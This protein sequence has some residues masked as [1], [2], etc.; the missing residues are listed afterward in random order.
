MADNIEA[1]SRRHPSESA[2]L[3]EDTL[4]PKLHYR[5]VQQRPTQVSRYKLKGYRVVRPSEDGVETLYDQE[6]KPAE[7]IIK[8]GDRVLMAIP[9]PK[10]H[11]LAARVKE[12]AISRLQTNEEKFR[13]T[14]KRRGVKIHDKDEGD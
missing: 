2:I 13:S 11:Q 3:K 12:R 4:D 1:K 9:K 5:F 10:Y 14:A 8:H 6:D 7:D